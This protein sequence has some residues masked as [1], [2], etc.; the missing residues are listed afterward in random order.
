MGH[1]IPP[2]AR[3][4]VRKIADNVLY[5][6]QAPELVLSEDS[7]VRMERFEEIDDWN[8]PQRRQKE[9]KDPPPEKYSIE[10]CNASPCPCP[11]ERVIDWDVQMCRHVHVHP[12]GHDASAH[13][14]TTLASVHAPPCP[15]PP[16]RP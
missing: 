16:E 13:T 14:R 10:V 5:V 12:R 4:Q 9:P 11:P 1:P 3:T 2:C 8:R 15:C 6:M 7:F